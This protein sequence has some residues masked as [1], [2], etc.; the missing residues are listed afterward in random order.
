MK[1]IT[2]ILITMAMAVGVNA[3]NKRP[4]SKQNPLVIEI[5]GSFAVGGT[6]FTA[7]GNFEVANALKPDG[8]TFHG[9][10]AYVFYQVP[11][12]AHKYPLVFLHGAGQSKKRGKPH[13]TDGRAFKTFFYGKGLACICL[14]SQDVEKRAKVSLRQQ[15]SPLRTNSFGL[16][17]SG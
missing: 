17:N 4:K 15:L 12:K 16:P 2:L 11:L 13:L 6:M 7:P 10:H 5:Q 9:D 8:Q 3:Q 1:Q 14:T